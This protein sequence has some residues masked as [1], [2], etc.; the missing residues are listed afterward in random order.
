VP[1]VHFSVRWPD[2]RSELFYSP[3]LIVEEYFEPGVGYPL[4]EFV[5]KSR[6]CMRIADA[7]VREKYG[8]GCAESRATL[9]RIEAKA[10]RYSATDDV[11]VEGFHR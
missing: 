3:S 10:A 8:F 7:R 6:T 4:A 5:D 11:T 2:G 1:E 9:A